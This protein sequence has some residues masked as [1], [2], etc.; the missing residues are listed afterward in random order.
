[1]VVD[2]LAAI[3]RRNPKLVR[4]AVE[5]H[6]NGDIPPNTHVV[7]YDAVVKNAAAI[8]RKS[9][10]LGLTTFF[11]TKQFGHNPLVARAVMEGGIEKAVAVDIDSARILHKGGIPVGHVG[12]LV[13]VPKH[14]VQWVVDELRPDIIT[15]YSVEKAAQISHAAKKSRLEQKV[16]LRVVGE[17]DFF[18]PYQ[19]GG[20]PE[21]KLLEAGRAISRLSHILLAGVTSFP[22]FRFNVL[23]T[24]EEPL[25]NASTLRRAAG[26]LRRGG[27]DATTV[28]MPGDTSTETLEL[29]RDFGGTQGE[30]GHALTGTTPANFFRDLPEKPASLYVSEISHKDANRAHSIGVPYV[31][32]VVG[33]TDSL[34]HAY[35]ERVLVGSDPDKISEH[36]YLADSIV[37]GFVDYNMPIRTVENDR[38][39]RVGDSVVMGFRAQTWMTRAK[40]A[41]VKGL[42]RGGKYKLL[43]VY[44]NYGDI[45]GRA[46]PD[47]FRGRTGLTL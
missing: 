47:S 27:F 37:P 2:F 11:M 28:N 42:G 17:R 7:D 18:Y 44:N 13:Q 33:I 24:K 25:P 5:L 19:E 31:D 46:P 12:H 26:A 38:H 39:V 22:C 34:Y 10:R 35:R 23:T 4:T 16:L 15:V 32:K 20:I 43:G 45:F 36:E 29:I 40:T 21:A 41:V 3:I 6:Q 8:S 1:L 9:G 14:D 30:P